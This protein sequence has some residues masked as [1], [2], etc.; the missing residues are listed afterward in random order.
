MQRRKGASRS[1]R[2]L[3]CAADIDEE[4]AWCVQEAMNW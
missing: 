4:D 3:A 1:S 2:I